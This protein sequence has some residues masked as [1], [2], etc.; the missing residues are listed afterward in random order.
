MR[1]LLAA[2]GLKR[3]GLEDKIAAL[4]P[5][6]KFPP[7]CGQGTIAIECREADSRM[8]DLLAEIDHRPS[9]RALACERAF[10]ASLDGSC[11]TPIAGYARLEG[12]L[13]RIDGV[14]LSEDGGESYEASASGDPGN[15]VEIGE[16]GGKEIRR[17]AP[18]T[19]LAP[20]RDRLSLP[21]ALMRLAASAR[22]DKPPVDLPQ[23]FQNQP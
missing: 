23:P 17:K 1:R 7:A 8:L 14:V 9:S 2:A 16:E 4:L 19:F 15:A 21:G 3:I 22:C 5:L 10:L 20:A 12:L 11:K 18:S 13:L 6:E